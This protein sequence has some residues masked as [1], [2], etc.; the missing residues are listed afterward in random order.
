MRQTEK[1]WPAG[2]D[3][4]GFRRA[5]ESPPPLP[6]VVRNTHRFADGID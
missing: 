3:G 4:L 1:N 2:Q 6:S 5:H